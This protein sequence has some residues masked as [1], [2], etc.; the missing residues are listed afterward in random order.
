MVTCLTMAI[1]EHMRFCLTAPVATSIWVGDDLVIDGNDEFAAFLGRTC[2]AAVL[3]RPAR[4]GF[5]PHWDVLEPL[6]MRAPCVANGVR[7]VFDRNVPREEV[8]ATLVFTKFEGGLAV[9]S[10]SR[11]RVTSSHGDD[12]RRC[13]TWAPLRCVRTRPTRPV[14]PCWPCSARIPMTS[15]MPTIVPV[16]APRA[17]AWPISSELALELEPNP[18]RPMD[19]TYTAFFQ[20]IVETV[21]PALAL[22]DRRFARPPR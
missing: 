1:P 14:R 7:L 10:G 17:G 21:I 9:T 5:G 2:H 22:G 4:E 11:R 3:G 12:S 20:R 6:A 16:G 19:A 18:Q 15:Q 13:A 8:F